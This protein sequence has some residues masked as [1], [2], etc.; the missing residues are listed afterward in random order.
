MVQDANNYYIGLSIVLVIGL[1]LI[2]VAFLGCC[3]AFKESQCLLVTFFCFLLVVV[4]AEIAAGAWAFTNKDKL[5]DIVRDTVKHTVQEEY[6][7]YAT[8]TAAFD[9][10]QKM[11]SGL[12]FPYD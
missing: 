8:R 12:V 3:G 11:V 1:V 7:V 6:S 4:T 9:G 2:I 5:T 10:V